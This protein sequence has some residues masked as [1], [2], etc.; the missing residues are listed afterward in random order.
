MLTLKF[1]NDL[2]EKEKY[3]KFISS[4]VKKKHAVKFESEPHKQVIARLTYALYNKKTPKGYRKISNTQ[5][6]NYKELG[7]DL[8][9]VYTLVGNR[10]IG[11]YWELTNTAHENLKLDEADFKED[12]VYSVS[13]L[14]NIVSPK[15]TTP[16][17]ITKR[18]MPN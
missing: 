7:I 16:I 12:G 17:Y 1:K 9:L 13:I 18:V 2:T 15:G 11:E 4:E 5:K 10:Y 14:Q 6:F 8:K 3:Y